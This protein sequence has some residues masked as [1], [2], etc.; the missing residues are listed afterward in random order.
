MR[1]P[2]KARRRLATTGVVNR[3]SPMP[4]GLMRSMFLKFM[5]LG[6][7]LG[8]GHLMAMAAKLIVVRGYGPAVHFLKADMPH[9]AAFEVDVK[10]LGLDLNGLNAELFGE[11]G[12]RF[13]GIP[14]FVVAEMADVNLVFPH[15]LAEQGVHKII[16]AEF[17]KTKQQFLEI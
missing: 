9:L 5:D 7:C 11:C 4:C 17:K 13:L 3:T 16:K 6:L 12:Q 10:P 2:G 8:D 1:A 15:V 14:P